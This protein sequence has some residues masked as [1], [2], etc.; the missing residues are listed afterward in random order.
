MRHDLP[1]WH[2]D[3][4]RTWL[5]IVSSAVMLTLTPAGVVLAQTPDAPS[6]ATPQQAAALLDQ[7][8]IVVLHVGDK[9]EYEKEHLPR[10][11]HLELRTLYPPA[12]AGELTLQLPPPADLEARLEALGIGDRTP[13]LVYMGSNQVSPT[14]RVVFTLDY[15]GL[16]GQTFVLDGGLPAW[17]AANLPVTSEVP[18]A[19][20]TGT[21][22]LASRS[23]AVA[24]LAEVK[25]AAGAAG[26]RV[27]DARAREFYTGESNNNGRIPRPGHVSGA[28][29]VPYT[30]FVQEDGRFR[31]AADVE[32]L[33]KSAGVTR[34]TRLITYCHIGQQA[35][36]PWLMA[37]I[38]GYDVQLF[39]GSYEEWARTP[40]APVTSGPTP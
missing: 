25:T 12:G 28:V 9:V 22:T 19:P 2:A 34:G 40:D 20:A 17:K 33:L 24:T 15:A 14:T 10:A 27:L 8:G 13:V 30:S 6:I 3:G 35:T 39:D 31:S 29:S 1:S 4:M 18:P 32:A 16:G 23:T 21:L 26:H 7:P 37:R 11:R 36:V 5:S 38:L